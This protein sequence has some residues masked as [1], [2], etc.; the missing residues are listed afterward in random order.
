[1]KDRQRKKNKTIGARVE[2]ELFEEI[3]SYLSKTDISI[4]QLIRRS[5]IEHMGAHPIKQE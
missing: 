3:M 2:Q 1:M 4:G 5:V